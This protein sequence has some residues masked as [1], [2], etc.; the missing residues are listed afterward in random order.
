MHNTS[1]QTQLLGWFICLLATCFSFYVYFE[2]VSTSIL[3]EPLINRYHLNLQSYGLLAASYYWAYTPLQAIVGTLMDYFGVK[4]LMLLALFL[5]SIGACLF[6]I[7]SELSLAFMG[8]FLMGFGSAFSFVAVLKLAADWLPYRYFSFFSGFTTALSMLGAICGEMLLERMIEHNGLQQTLIYAACIAPI[9]FIL[10]AILI[11]DTPPNTK[12]KRVGKADKKQKPR[13]FQLI[14]KHLV[15]D[16]FVVLQN[17]QCWI[18]GLI[19]ACLFIPTTIFAEQWGIGYLRTVNHLSIL[20]ASSM[21]SAIFVGWA[22]GSPLMS[23]CSEYLKKR[24][25]PL[26]IG[27]AGAAICASLA[28]YDHHLSMSTMSILFFLFGFF[29]SVEILV[30]PIAHDLIPHKLSGTAV[31]ITNMFVNLGGFIQP[32]IGFAL[33]WFSAHTYHSLSNS[34]YSTESY[35]YAL[36]IVPLCFIVSLIL[37]AFFLKET[38]CKSIYTKTDEPR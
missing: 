18:N 12:Q 26:I 13:S 22:V 21:T 10:S 24:C 8:R 34:H 17:R 14:M 28:L 7:S 9:L 36:L 20:S 15:G 31:A 29:S 19:G 4:R 16:I 32:L 1:K 30:F 2:R 27:S 35:E 11:K 37:S 33:V 3:Q 5:C 23:L 25:L 38:H 6:G